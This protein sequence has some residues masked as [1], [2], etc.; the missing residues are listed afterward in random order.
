MFSASVFEICRACVVAA[1]MKKA[2][3]SKNLFMGFEF[4]ASCKIL[5]PVFY[6][7]FYMFFQAVR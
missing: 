3:Q 6:V 5:K 4:Y 2:K 1:K 7:K